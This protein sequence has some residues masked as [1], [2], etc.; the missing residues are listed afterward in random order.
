MKPNA[1]AM[2]GF[3]PQPN[4]HQLF[5][6][7]IINRK[8]RCDWLVFFPGQDSANSEAIEKELYQ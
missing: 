5:D 1:L 4:L 6:P 2:L 7:E 3:V 8:R